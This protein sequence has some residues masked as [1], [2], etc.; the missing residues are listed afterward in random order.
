[1]IYALIN[2]NVVVNTIVADEAFVQSIEEQYQYVVR[3]D[4]LVPKPGI[5]W[6]YDGANFTAPVEE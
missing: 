6:S 2:N 1:M 3:I 5:D 4:Q